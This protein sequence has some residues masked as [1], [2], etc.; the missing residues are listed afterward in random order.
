[1]PSSPIGTTRSPQTKKRVDALIPRQI[2]TVDEWLRTT[3]ADVFAAGDVCMTRKYA[4]VARASARLVVE[5]AFS[6]EMRRKS[7]LAV[8]WCT[9]CDPEIAH[10]GIQ[11]WQARERSVPVKTYTVMMQV[12]DRAITDGQDAGFV[13]IHVGE[14]T[15]RILGATIVATRASEMINE[16]SVAMSAGIGLRELARVLHTYP[17]QCEAIRMAAEAYVDDL[18]RD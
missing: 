11:V 18:P 9:S 2:L 4:N 7:E 12:V 6:G 5:N 13:K 8:P 10:I 15:D 14:G 3:N 16:I 17:S 1:M